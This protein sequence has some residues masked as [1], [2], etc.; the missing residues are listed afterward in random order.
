M[1]RLGAG[2]LVGFAVLAALVL[3][4]GPGPILGEEHVLA[5]LEAARTPEL[6]AWVRGVTSLGGWFGQLP[7]VIGSAVL[8][9]ATGRRKEAGALLLL[10][11]A[12]YFVMNGAK[13][14]MDRPR[15]DAAHAV[16]RATGLSFPSGHASVSMFFFLGLGLIVRREGKRWPL[17]VLVAIAMLVGLTRPY[18]GVH[19]PSDVVGG[20]LM[21]GGLTLVGAGWV[22]ARGRA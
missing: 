19:Y 17:G 22:S 21:A 4:L 6:T 16:Y 14:A 7:L 8:L 13:L 2:L 12:G 10:C 15:P 9:A 1:T 18:L 3:A 11:L 5:G 20:W